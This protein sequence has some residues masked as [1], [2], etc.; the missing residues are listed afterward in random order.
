VKRDQVGEFVF[1][2]GETMT[3]SLL[4]HLV[5][6]TSGK[7]VFRKVL[8]SSQNICAFVVV[9]C[10]RVCVRETVHLLVN[11]VTAQRTVNVTQTT[12]TA[13]ETRFL[14][15]A[16]SSGEL[17][18]FGGGYNARGEV[19]A[20]VGICNVTSG[21]WT[22]AALSVLRA[23]LAAASSGNPIFFARGRNVSYLNATYYSQVDIYN[24][25]DGRW[26]TANL[27]QARCY[28]AATSVRNL[29]LFGGGYIFTPDGVY[30]DIDFNVVDIYVVTSN[31]WAYTYLS[32]GCDLLAAT[33][34]GNQFAVFAGGYVNSPSNVVDIFDSLHGL[35]NTSTMSQAR[36]NLA[37][38][39]LGDLAFFGGGRMTGHQIFNLVDIFNSTSQT[40]SIVTLN[41]ARHALAAASIGDV[42]AFG[43]GSNIS[44]YS[45][46]VDMY[47]VKSNVS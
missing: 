43:G 10:V 14:L 29:V 35:R 41:Q 11:C 13:S 5:V 44:T 31:T 23:Y 7:H 6:P 21:N 1:L 24:T 30:Y 17:V 4:S 9:W 46:V 42:V 36:Y 8:L 16:T 27:S 37:A 25:S 18:F 28:L 45:I 22:I 19:S 33:S 2:F 47:Y 34:V 15:A 12:A 32:Q 39:S 38:T 20:Q 26:S 3:T 40:W